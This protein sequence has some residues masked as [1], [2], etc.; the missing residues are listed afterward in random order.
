MLL[1]GFQQLSSFL[2]Q[3]YLI[4]HSDNT[5]EYSPEHSLDP[6]CV[7]LEGLDCKYKQRW[8]GAGE[9]HSPACQQELVLTRNA[10]LQQH[11]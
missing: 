10:T 5:V 9:T 7:S 2:A 8:Q 1:I 4:W 3:I 11:N 6:S